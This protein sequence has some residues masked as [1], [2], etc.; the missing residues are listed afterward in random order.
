[1][2]SYWIKWTVIIFTAITCPEEK[3]F[4]PVTQTW[5]EPTVSHSLHCEKA[6]TIYNQKTFVDSLEAIQFFEILEKD[7]R[8]EEAVLKGCANFVVPCEGCPPVVGF[9]PC[10]F[11]LREY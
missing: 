11:V 9:N 7:N 8:V 6:D 3:V 2:D 5:N 10:P 4:D 1:M